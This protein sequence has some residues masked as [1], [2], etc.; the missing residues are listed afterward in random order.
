[1]RL[2]NEGKYFVIRFD[3]RDVGLSTHLDHC[4]KP[5]ILN[6]LFPSWATTPYDLDDMAEDAVALLD[7]LK[8]KRAHIFGASMGGMIAQ[9]VALLHPDRVIT[10]T[11]LFSTTGAKSL[12]QAAFSVRKEFLKAPASETVE[13]VT[14]FRYGMASKVLFNSAAATVEERDYVRSRIHK[15][16]A[17]STYRGGAG[18]Q[19][20]AVLKSPDR[21]ER[22][23]SLKM[24]TLVL[25]GD[26][27]RLILP[28]H[29]YATAAAIPDA[30]LVIFPG[31]GHYILP[32]YWD[33]IVD[34]FLKFAAAVKAAPA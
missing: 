24:P 10:L 33:M 25:H 8:I 31:M 12:P 16:A 22:L 9:L 4:G 11:S 19:T 13:A 34:A 20:L 23:K 21:T 30:S 29:G 14:D 2:V 5:S 1:M 27:D 26:D 18:R 32:R 7:V 6:M 3:N 17:R 15:G 28:Q